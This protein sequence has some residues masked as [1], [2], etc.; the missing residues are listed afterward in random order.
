[1][2]RRIFVASAGVLLVAL[3]GPDPALAFDG[4]RMLF[5]TQYPNFTGFPPTPCQLCH[6]NPQGF[7]PWNAYGWSLRQLG[8][9]N[10][11]GTPCT[12]PKFTDVESLDAD[13]VGGTNIQEITLNTQPGW[14]D[15]ATQGC[16]NLAYFKD[17]H[18][19]A[20][21]PPAGVALDPVVDTVAPFAPTGLAATLAS[22]T[23]ISLSWTAPTD[24][25]G[26]TGY[27]VDRCTGATCSN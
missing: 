2:L 19:S 17:G 1:M 25:V 24:N 21:T 22:A 23:Q 14:C 11:S 6:V 27:Q 18:T 13:A 15:P 7:E 12:A 4:C 26:V 3:A 5:A 8:T 9:A 10:A 16:V 20:A